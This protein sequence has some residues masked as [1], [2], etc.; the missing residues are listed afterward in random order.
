MQAFALMSSELQK[1]YVRL[2]RC[3]KHLRKGSPMEGYLILSRLSYLS[4][5]KVGLKQSLRDFLECS[6]AYKLT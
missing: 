3:M 6:T 2:G 4:Y 5:G 1:I